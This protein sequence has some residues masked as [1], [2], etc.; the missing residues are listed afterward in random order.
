VC[1][2][3]TTVLQRGNHKG[4]LPPFPA[5]LQIDMVNR[6]SSASILSAGCWLQP[7]SESRATCNIHLLPEGTGTHAVTLTGCQPPWVNREF[8]QAVLPEKDMF[9]THG[10]Q[11]QE[12]GWGDS[13]LMQQGISHLGQSQG[14][15]VSC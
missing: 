14:S 1:Q 12:K 11:L 15:T 3:V 6:G 9:S 13:H 2:A 10:G 5:M 7:F 8:T 4:P